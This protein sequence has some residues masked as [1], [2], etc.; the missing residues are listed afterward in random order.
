MPAQSPFRAFIPFTPQ[1]QDHPQQKGT[2]AAS[3]T[4]ATAAIA[5]GPP[6]VKNAETLTKLPI[7]YSAA[8]RLLAA[9]ATTHASDSIKDK[10]RV[11]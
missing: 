3:N 7:S 9:S 11:R 1:V 6:E 10:N 4:P 8:R 5:S 2:S